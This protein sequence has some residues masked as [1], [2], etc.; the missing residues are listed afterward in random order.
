MKKIFITVLTVLS[1]YGCNQDI[2]PKET[3]S[4]YIEGLMEKKEKAQKAADEAN[5]QINKLQK[6]VQEVNKEF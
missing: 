6:S 1:F 4:G 3:E 2:K 5:M